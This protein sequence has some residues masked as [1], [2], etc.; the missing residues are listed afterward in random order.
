MKANEKTKLILVCGLPGTGKT[1]VAEAIAKKTNARILSTDILRKEL[2][3]NPAYTED[4]KTL[5]YSMLFNMAGMLLKD[6]RNVVL[7]GTFYKKE[8]RDN[9][10]ELATKTR[11]GLFVVEVVCDE[12]VVRQRLEKRCKTCCASDADFAVYKKLRKSFEQIKEKHFTI[13]TSGAWQKHADEIA[14]KI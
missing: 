1:S 11:S 7:D 4:E 12:S 2:L 13:D 3:S 10:R 14:A 6:G 9:V 5:V 8:L